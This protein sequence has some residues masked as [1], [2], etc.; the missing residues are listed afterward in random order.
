MP[1]TPAITFP[2]DRV[3]DGRIP[4]ECPCGWDRHLP[5][6]SEQSHVQRHFQWAHGPVVPAALEPLFWTVAAVPAGAPAPWTRLAHQA[7]R[8][9]QRDGRYDFPSF[10]A[11]GTGATGGFATT[12]ALL[13]RHGR[14]IRGYLALTTAPAPAQLAPSGQITTLPDSEVTERTCVELIWTAFHW[15]RQG[16]AADLIRTAAR[17]AGTTPAEIAWRTPLTSAGQALATSAAPGPVWLA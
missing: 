8:L 17:H 4:E 5:E 16:I 6:L 13:Y 14:R 1:D 3:T 2:D 15:R 12:R 7:A 11:P 9:A 10:P